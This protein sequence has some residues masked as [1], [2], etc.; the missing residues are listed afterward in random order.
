M[1][2][3][4]KKSLRQG[5]RRVAPRKVDIYI[6]EA[7]HKYRAYSLHLLPAHIAF[8]LLWSVVPLMLL[9][10]FAQEF[11]SSVDFELANVNIDFLNQFLTEKPVLGEISF[12][13]NGLILLATVLFFSSRAF[14]SIIH[15]SN[16]VYGLK[17]DKNFLK[18]RAKGILLS[19][20]FMLCFVVMLILTILGQGI[21]DLF[22]SLF[23]AT[24]WIEAIRPLRWPVAG[25]VLFLMVYLLYWIAPSKKLYWKIPIPGTCFTVVLWSMASWV[26][27]FYLNNL[28]NYT[29]VYT[30]FSNVIILM[31]WLYLISYI[32]VLGMLLNAIYLER[33]VDPSGQTL[34]NQ[35]IHEEYPLGPPRT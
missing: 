23:G 30:S 11:F 24:R 19:I 27:S 22:E 6:E 10:D 15:V 18:T 8:F 13:I 21:L 29:R 35:D 14:F 7:Y 12:S 16:Y 33:H 25:V 17:K 32:F 20:C 26:Y 4:L 34:L 3:E 5:L 1:I 28:A 31:I 2:T 9:W